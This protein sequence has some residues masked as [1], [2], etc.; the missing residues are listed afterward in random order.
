MRALISESL[1]LKLPIQ[2]RPYDVRDTRLKGFIVRVQAHTGAKSFLVDYKRGRKYTLGRYPVLS[3][4]E[5]RQK[6]RQVLG[7]VFTGGD[8]QK[9]LRKAKTYTLETFLLKEYLPWAEAHLRTAK[10]TTKR[11]LHDYSEF[12]HVHLGAI[13]PWLIEKSRSKRFKGGLSA[14]TVNRSVGALKTVLNRA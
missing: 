13:D 8:P 2:D 7:E 10:A 12:M 9:A 3:L 1:I 11:I 14:A 4:K 5:A 6:A